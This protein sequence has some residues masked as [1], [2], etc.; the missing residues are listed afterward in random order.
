MVSFLIV[1][2]AVITI[3]FRF[4]RE[5]LEGYTYVEKEADPDQEPGVPDIC[6]AH[7]KRILVYS[8][9][10]YSSIRMLCS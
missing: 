3:I 5:V 4:R 9:D 8:N 6:R 10:Y 7:F 2:G 1:S